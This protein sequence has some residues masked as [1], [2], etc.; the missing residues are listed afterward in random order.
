M[1]TEVQIMKA[2]KMLSLLLAVVLALSLLPT[3]ASAVGT[4]AETTEAGFDEKASPDADANPIAG[5]LTSG[6]VEVSTWAELGAALNAGG[7]IVLTAD[8]TPENPYWADALTV[9]SGVTATLDLNGHTVDRGYG[10]NTEPGWDGS[11]I[12]ISGT[13]TL[14]DSDPAAG[15]S[16]TGGFPD[17]YGGGVQILGGTFNLE[18]GSITGN[19]AGKTGF[20]GTEGLGGGVYLQSGT[21]N[22]SGGSIS[23]NKALGSSMGNPLGRGGGVYITGGTFNFTGGTISGN[24]AGAIGG[25]VYLASTYSGHDGTINVSG[26]AT[27]TDNTV[28][29]K[30]SNVYLEEGGVL[31]VTGALT[32]T[33]GVTMQTPGTFTSGLSGNGTKENFK[34]DNTDYG[35]ALS[36]T[37]ATLLPSETMPAAV[38]TATGPDTG[39]LSNVTAGMTYAID[40]GAA[41]EITGASVD[42]TGLAPCTIKVVQPGN[43]TTTADSEAQSIAVTK[44]ET[45]NLAVTQPSTIGG[46]GTIPTDSTHEYRAEGDAAWTACTGETTGLAAGTYYVRV[47][48]SGT[49]LASAYQTVTINAFVPTQE[50]TPN[51]TFTAT[52]Y[53]TGTLTGVTAGMTYAIDGGT[54]VTITDTSVELTD[55]APCT[56]TVM[57]PG[58]GTTTI[59]SDAQTITVTRAET[60]NLAVT[61]P[62]TIGGRGVVETTEAHEW[63]SNTYDWEDCSVSQ[64]WPQ[65]CTIFI[66][67]KA[68][69]TVLASAYQTVTI[70]AFVP[71]Q[72][73]TP[74]A[75]FTATGYDTGTL[76]GVTAGMTYAIDGGSAVEIAG[77]TVDLTGLVPCTITILQPGNGT[78][79][80][81]SDA[82]TITVTRAETPTLEP[83]QPSVFGGKG[84][85]PTDSTHE[86]RAEG[87]AEWTACTG[88][89]TGLAAGTYYV[90]VAAVGTVLA[91]DA[92][93][94]VID[95][96]P[97]PLLADETSDEEEGLPFTDVHEDDWFY[98]AVVW[99]Y[100]DVATGTTDTTF[101]PYA[102][103]T[104][105]QMVTFLWRAAGRP[106]PGATDNPFSDVDEGAYYYKAVLWAV[107]N[108][109]T[110]G[111]GGGRFD[112]DGTVSRAQ[113]VTFLWR[114][115]GGGAGTE[116]PFAD[117][118]DGMYF[119]DAVLWAVENG[120]TQGTSAT[121]FSPDDDCLRAQIVTFLYR[122]YGEK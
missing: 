55:L 102:T 39:T 110:Q 44:A 35:V 86:Y 101:S 19:S 32:G 62:S 43:G 24:D 34:S 29:T 83:V 105:A 22:M 113:S 30:N 68:S 106:E 15:G 12:I 111:I 53:D 82:Q 78:T 59:D 99:A 70:N 85:I 21:F 118:Q 84:T 103:C 3:A 120:I 25:G 17:Q 114:A 79:T 116:N 28:G 37:E 95:P 14:M 57:L 5:V 40:G 51:A 63:S 27:V 71:T 6:T 54:A 18:G 47:K 115:L 80:I 23:G 42:L 93:E 117:V 33:I 49:V 87:D 91:S 66:R 26:G 104:R 36:G 94:I 20:F 100:P 97:A 45:P 61:Q 109:I 92:Q 107:E 9:P 16:I 88:E 48:A 41:V 72:E 77:T 1:K 119:Y 46:T 38:F 96:A 13:L 76:T 121:T 73:P 98:D 10:S 11:V 67:V 4:A 74:N 8:V 89:T 64:D 65:D 90:R 2:K 75:T 50:P 56:I 81:D 60:P 108:G 69:G 52:G 31:T 7:R 122:A 112:P 58:N